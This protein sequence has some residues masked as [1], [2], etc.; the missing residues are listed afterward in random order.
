MRLE[1]VYHEIN[2]TING[3]CY[4]IFIGITIFLLKKALTNLNVAT[5]TELKIKSRER[6][7]RKEIK[8]EIN[9]RTTIKS[10]IHKDILSSTRDMQSFIF[11]F[12]PIFYPI[13][14]MFSMFG[15]ISNEITSIEAIM[16]MW[17]IVM[18]IY[19]FIPPLVI[20][21]L[22]NLEESGS[23]TVA[24][25][26]M[27]PRE[28]AKAKIVLMSSI[29]AISLTLIAIILTFVLN[30]IMI[31]LLLLISLPIAWTILLFMF[32]I[33]IRLFGKMKYK[34]IV[35]ELHKEHKVEKWIIMIAS[36]IAIYFVILII[37]SILFLIYGILITLIVLAIIG[38]IGLSIVIFIFTRM[39]PKLE[40]IA[41]Y[42][43]GGFLREHP[44]V[45]ALV[46]MI[47]FIIFLY[48]PSFIEAPFLPLL[49]NLPLV[50][51]LFI[52]FFIMMGSLTLLWIIIVPFGLKLPNYNQSFKDFSQS[53]GL[54]RIRPLWR[55]ISLGILGISAVII[56][57]LIFGSILGKVYFYP[58][59]LTSPPNSPFP[60]LLR[61]GWFI[62]FMA[63]RPGIWEEFAFRGVILNMQLKK[64]SI[65]SSIIING[66]LFGLSHL[67]NLLSA[68]LISTL[69]QVFYATCFG[70][71][72]SY[73]YIKTRS[74]L[75]CILT[76]YLFDSIG[77][78]FVVTNLYNPI[79]VVLFLIF[80][81]GIIPMILIILFTKIF[82]YNN[83]GF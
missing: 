17:S 65:I 13:V 68:D 26:P 51:T 56:S 80:G 15:V 3:V 73:M 60:G 12:M 41:I 28:Q 75:P 10:Y 76:H 25:L 61:Y 32:E 58:E 50:E 69:F 47:L 52:D 39:F 24:S 33:K 40:K 20:V 72:L 83:R 66:F 54:T 81:V 64:Y 44:Y 63:L 29:Q 59:A 43:T 45:G 46:L 53:I 57:E 21:G 19:L 9:R 49:L 35:E 79:S 70:I 48:I 62:L 27:L 31:L 8:V 71:G 34:Y 38:F 37:G 23:S 1:R 82:S 2:L 77:Q 16:I 36:E 18:L 22:L 67:I 78:I 5:S 42:K 6:E 55:N 11:F 7:V 30:S 14:F 4:L 74:L